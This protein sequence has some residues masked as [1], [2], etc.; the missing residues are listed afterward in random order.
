MFKVVIGALI[1]TKIHQHIFCVFFSLGRTDS[2][3]IETALFFCHY[4]VITRLS[5]QKLF[6]SSPHKIVFLIFFLWFNDRFL[7]QNLSYSFTLPFHHLF[8]NLDFFMKGVLFC[9]KSYNLMM[10]V[11]VSTHNFKIKL[12]LFLLS[13]STHI[14]EELTLV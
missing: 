2:I 10:I 1:G 3:S 8:E 13:I 11:L 6:W 4:H 7:N 12:L 9:L 5:Y 14:L